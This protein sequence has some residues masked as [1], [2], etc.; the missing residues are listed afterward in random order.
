MTD[1]LRD[2]YGALS[3]VDDSMG[4]LRAVLEGLNLADD[5]VIVFYSDNGFLTGDHGL[6]DKRNA[7]EASVKVPMIVYAPKD[8]KGG[9]TN[10]TRIRNLDLAPTFLDIAGIQKPKQ[11]EGKSAWPLITGEQDRESWGNQTFY[12]ST[13]GSGASL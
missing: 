2:Y 3:S 4:R 5:T 6:I 12:I 1:Y 7:Y 11:F 10:K 13:I 8:A 9:S